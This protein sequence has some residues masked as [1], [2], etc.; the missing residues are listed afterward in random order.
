MRSDEY[1]DEKHNY[2]AYMY[3]GEGKPPTKIISTDYL[4]VVY[5]LVFLFSVALNHPILHD[6]ALIKLSRPAP[7]TDYVNTICLDANYTVPDY[8][9]CRTSGW[10]LVDISKL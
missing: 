3:Q 7:R 4:P 10:G 6:I 5:Y 1:P 2:T 9:V 8:T